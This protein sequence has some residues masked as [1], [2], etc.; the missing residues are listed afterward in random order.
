MDVLHSSAIRRI[1]PRIG[2]RVALGL[3]MS[4]AAIAG[5]AVAASASSAHHFG[6]G[7]GG[8]IA[9]GEVNSAPTT[10]ATGSTFTITSRGETVTVDVSGTT[11]HVEQGVSSPSVSD[12]GTGDFVALFGTESGTTVTATEVNIFVPKSARPAPVA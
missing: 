6:G 11:N 8:P 4:V 1:R 5:S 3:A 12:V 10:T 9:A 7:L 2:L